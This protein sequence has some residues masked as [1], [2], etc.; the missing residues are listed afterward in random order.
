MPSEWEYV[1]VPISSVDAP[2]GLTFEALL[3]LSLSVYAHEGWELAAILDN[4]DA[5][6][7]L[8]FVRPVQ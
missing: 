4:E 3:Q 2:S 1:E 8:S 7:V 5:E 6:V